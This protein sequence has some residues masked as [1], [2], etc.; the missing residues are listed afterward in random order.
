MIIR[1]RWPLI[2]IVMVVLAIGLLTSNQSE[3]PLDRAYRICQDCGLYEPEIDTLI[4]QI[5]SSGLTAKEA[6]EV[7]KQTAESDAVELCRDCVEAVV[8]VVG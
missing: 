5:R 6:I 7:W 1:T 4:E 2:V 3:T 8:G